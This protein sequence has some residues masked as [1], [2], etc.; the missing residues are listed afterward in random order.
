MKAIW[1][2][3]VIALSLGTVACGSAEGKC[4]SACKKAADCEESDA[5]Y[6]DK[7]DCESGCEDL[8]EAAD[9]ADCNSEFKDVVSC[10]KSNFECDGS[11]FEECESELT[12]Y[13]ECFAGD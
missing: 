13:A 4:K 3:A 8:A 7:A 6:Q 5:G 2:A 10:G 1:M 9:E 11:G 12:A